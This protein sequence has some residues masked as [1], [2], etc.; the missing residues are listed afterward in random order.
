MGNVGTRVVALALLP[1]YCMT[2]G[3][4]FL[5]LGLSVLI[6]KIIKNIY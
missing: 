3:K 4:I 2:L 5:H 6:L 1:A